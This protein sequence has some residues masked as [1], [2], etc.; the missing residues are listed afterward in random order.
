[1]ITKSSLSG[2]SDRQLMKIVNVE[3]DISKSP[4]LATVTLSCGCK[5]ERPASRVPRGQNMYCHD[6]REKVNAG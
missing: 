2:G 5:V 6:C 4:V 3:Y 1:M